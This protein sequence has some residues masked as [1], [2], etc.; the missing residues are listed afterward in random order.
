M[1]SATNPRVAAMA[2]AAVYIKSSTPLSNEEAASFINSY[3]QD[4]EDMVNVAAST[5][6]TIDSTSGSSSVV[7]DAMASEMAQ[8]EKIV[9]QLKR[10]EVTLHSYS[11]TSY[12]Y[13]EPQQNTTEIVEAESL[14][15][16]KPISKEERKRL[17]KER[18]K[19][20]RKE[21]LA[22]KNDEE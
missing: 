4:S 19:Q 1:S 6:M 16:E 18:K 9:A 7:I 21:E 17:K 22:S 14:D 13:S 8:N 11:H 15:A 12:D 10:V 2:P 5:A 3:I 20:A